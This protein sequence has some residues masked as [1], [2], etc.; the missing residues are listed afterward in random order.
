MLR[1]E[2]E[3]ARAQRYGRELTVVA[4]EP[5]SGPQEWAAQHAITDWLARNTRESDLVGYLGNG[6]F[7]AILTETEFPQ[8][9][10]FVTRLY[11]AIPAIELGTAAFPANGSSYVELSQRAEQMLRVAARMDDGSATAESAA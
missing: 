6:R 1:G 9:D 2:E 4:V 5:K 10:G 11:D 7:V 8:S 3:C